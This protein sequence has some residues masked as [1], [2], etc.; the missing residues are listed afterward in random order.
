M[1]FKNKEQAV[2]I[3]GDAFIFLVSINPE[4]A[5]GIIETLKQTYFWRAIEKVKTR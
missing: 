1:K 5:V 2:K 3:M 4:E